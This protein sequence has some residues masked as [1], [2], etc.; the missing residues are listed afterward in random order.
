MKR[1]QL[2]ASL[3]KPSDPVLSDSPCTFTL[4][5]EMNE[6]DV[7]LTKVREK[8]V[9]DDITGEASCTESLEAPVWRVEQACGAQGCAKRE[10]NFEHRS[11][12]GKG[13]K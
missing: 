8:T 10:I 1:A 13:A 12:L 6:F 11:R 7:S 2:F 9:I 3:Q 5:V 4:Q